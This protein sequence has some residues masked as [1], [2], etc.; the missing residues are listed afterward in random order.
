M[1]NTDYYISR[2]LQLARKGLGS[3]AP[4]PM[5]GCVI[6]HND[7]IIGEGFHRKYGEAHAEVIAVNSVKDKSKLPQSTVYVSL[8]PCAHFGKTPPCANLLVKHGVKKVVIC[9]I[10]PFA[11]VAGKGIEILKNAGIEVEV[12]VLSREGA[13]LNR[14]FFTF[15]TKKRPYIILKWAQSKNGFLDFN[16][17]KAKPES[18]AISSLASRTLVHKWRT[19]EYAILVGDKTVINDNPSLSARLFFGKSPK[20]IVLDPLLITPKTA[21]VYQQNKVDVFLFNTKKSEKF[22]N[23]NLIKVSQ[24]N[25]LEA[26]LEELHKLEVQSVLVEG[27]GFTLEKF[28][29]ENLWDE[30]RVFVSEKTI[31]G[32]TKAPK[33]NQSPEK[34]TQVSSD[35]LYFYYNA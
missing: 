5:V 4:N 25:F 10:D 33:I 7:L 19:E 35:R 27:G 6:V 14:R 21:N 20:I 13:F 18:L 16:L 26:V 22:N 8:E 24:T 3:V 31:D 2:C 34:Q 9:N 17:E 32:R 1:Q 12:G 23:I 11:K 15:H 29:S 28:I 30:A